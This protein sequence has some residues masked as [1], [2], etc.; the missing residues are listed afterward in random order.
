[1][2]FIITNGTVE[3]ERSVKP[4]DDETRGAR[5]MLS[6][7]VAEGSDPEAVMA[8][9]FDMAARE[10]HRQVG[11]SINPTP[12]WAP[13]VAL[14]AGDTLKTAPAVPQENPTMK[15]DAS[16]ATNAAPGVSTPA[17]AAT[18]GPK[19]AA[20]T[21]GPTATKTASPSNPFAI[22][23]PAVPQENPSAPTVDATSPSAPTSNSSFPAPTIPDGLTDQDLHAVAQQ[24]IEK[25]VKP[26]DIR[27]ITAKYAGQMGMTI[28]QLPVE[29]RAAWLADVR[30]L[31][32]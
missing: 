32:K 13:A 7:R 2:L 29:N 19:D 23:A 11:L 22:T 24:A 10:V 25:K 17:Q 28:S 16:S 1:M 14:D 6:Y 9:V 31:Y 4:D 30:A 5:V 21:P 12:Y 27:D 20:V 26:Q 3:Y 18:G 8:Q 15:P